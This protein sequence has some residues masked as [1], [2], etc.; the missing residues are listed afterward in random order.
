[1][2]L[3]EA[4][5]ALVKAF[6]EQLHKELP[7]LRFVVSMIWAEGVRSR[8]PNDKEWTNVWPGLELGA[9]PREHYP[10]DVIDRV[11]GVEIVF[12]ALDPKIFEGKTIDVRDH[13]LFVRD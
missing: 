9:D 11:D 10:P 6:Y 5:G 13:R 4:A 1:V 2:R 8:R 12:S 3:T 7:P